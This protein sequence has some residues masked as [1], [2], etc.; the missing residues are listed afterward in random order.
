M[1]APETMQARQAALLL[2]GLPPAARQRVIAK[3][4]IAETARLKPLLQELTELGVPQSLGQQFQGLVPPPQAITARPST[5][6]PTMREP[7]LQ[8]Q[9][10]ALSPEDIVQCLE[11]CAPVT[12]ARL[13]STRA[14]PWKEQ[15]LEGMPELRR[16]EVLRHL[17]GEAP[18]LAPAVQKAL[19]E[20]LCRETA[21]ARA[22]RS[23]ATNQL[24]RPDADDTLTR[25]EPIGTKL[26]RWIGWKR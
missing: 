3:L 22:A 14:W 17:R 10:D 21:R 5:P 7:T 13:L 25:I 15:V 9:A 20:R 1:S 2:H 26:R 18:A 23:D 24:V 16:N 19:W 11:S 12:V 8:E 4:N 6:P